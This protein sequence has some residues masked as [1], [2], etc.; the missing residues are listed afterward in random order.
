[1]MRKRWLWFLYFTA[2]GISCTH[3]AQRKGKEQPMIPMKPSTPVQ[4]VK[5]PRL[6][7]AADLVRWLEA[8]SQ[9]PDGKRRRFLLPVTVRFADEY[10]LAFGSVTIGSVSVVLDDTAMEVPLLQSISDRC[11][12]GQS[13]CSLWLEGYWGPLVDAPSM[14][15]FD[16]PGTKHFAV[17]RVQ[18]TIMDQAHDL[19]ASMETSP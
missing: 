18:Q 15:S 10:R 17:L 3:E 14:P 8:N 4:M 13:A 19:H 11:P 2:L 6:E 7:P 1:M 5:G 9:K 16:P 12:K